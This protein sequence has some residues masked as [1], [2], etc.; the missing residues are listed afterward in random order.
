[1]TLEVWAV[2]HADPVRDRLGRVH[3]YGDEKPDAYHVTKYAALCCKVR[4]QDRMPHRRW[5]VARLVEA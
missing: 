1:M 2:V 3:H 4:W 5:R